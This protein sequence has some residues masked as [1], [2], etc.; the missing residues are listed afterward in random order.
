[1]RTARSSLGSMA[2]QSGRY[3]KL[4]V[5]PALVAVVLLLGIGVI[6]IVE[7]KR[8]QA[9][10]GEVLSA[11]L[12]DEILHDA[13]DWGSGQRIQVLLQR[14]AQRGNS[15]WRWCM[16]LDGRLRFSQAAFT[17]RMSFVVNNTV[18]ADIRPELH[19]PEGQ[20]SLFS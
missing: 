3:T 1:M 6:S 20:S 4:A 11:Y 8:A 9:E 16:L 10:Y 14:E 12:C 15:R 5:L 18:A 2:I 13:H 17:T 19:L 7:Q